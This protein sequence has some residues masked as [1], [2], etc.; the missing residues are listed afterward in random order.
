VVAG[1]GPERGRL[2]AIAKERAPGRIH[3][4]GHRDDVADVLAA[5]DLFVVC[6]DREGM[7]NAMVEAL[8]A[9]VPVV[10]TP[11]SGAAEALAPIGTGVAPGVITPDFDPAGVRAAITRLLSDAPLRAA[12]AVEAK[13][14]A[15]DRFGVERGAAEWE[16]FL[17]A[18]SGGGRADGS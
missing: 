6:S 15:A 13:R 14:A 10:S 5:L 4:L 16:R 3:L 18:D 11:V 12:M 17:L 2:E 9:G 8:G 7:S 1:E